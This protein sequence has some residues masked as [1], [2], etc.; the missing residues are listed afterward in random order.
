[1]LGLLKLSTRHL[2]LRFFEPMG[3]DHI[4]LEEKANQAVTRNLEAVDPM[5]FAAKVFRV[6][7]LA[8]IRQADEPS[9]EFRLVG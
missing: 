2:L 6:A 3:Y 1:M 8:V 5:A 7:D 4:R 9:L